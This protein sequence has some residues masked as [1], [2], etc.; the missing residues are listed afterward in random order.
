[1]A[2][3]R[4]GL[5]AR[6]SRSGRPIMALLDLLGTDD[7]TTLLQNW[8]VNGQSGLIN[9]LARRWFEPLVEKSPDNWDFGEL[10]RHWIEIR[11]RAT[12]TEFDR[13]GNC[14]RALLDLVAGRAIDTHQ[15]IAEGD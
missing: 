12:L 10:P 2:R 5:P 14:H 9:S 8:Q 1:M 15:Y 7:A 6:G 13:E 11:D 4:P 3:I